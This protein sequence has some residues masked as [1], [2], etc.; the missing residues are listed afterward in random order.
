MMCL[1]FAHTC[2][3]R[4]AHGTRSHDAEHRTGTSEPDIQTAY[5]HSPKL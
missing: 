5:E 3:V 1:V 4:P 2:L